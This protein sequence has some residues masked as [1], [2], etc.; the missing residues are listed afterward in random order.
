MKIYKENHSKYISMNLEKIKNSVIEY[1]K[2]FKIKLGILKILIAAFILAFIIMIVFD[3]AE[4]SIVGD[5]ISYVKTQ[6]ATRSPFGL[7]L[8]GLIGGLFFITFPL[9]IAY[10][11]ALSATDSPWTYYGIMLGS[12]AIAYTFNYYAG[13]WLSKSATN[14]ISAKQFYTIKSKL[15]KYGNGVVLLFNILPLPSQPLT[16]ICGVFRY[17]KL[18]YAVLWT[19]GWGIK[20]AVL[21]QFTGTIKGILG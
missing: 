12:L 3:L 2:G 16:F 8:T 19:L 9:E 7:M 4:G 1:N 10:I 11:A 14:I 5:A 15:N 21:T 20:L 18:R 17:N 13:F 6:I